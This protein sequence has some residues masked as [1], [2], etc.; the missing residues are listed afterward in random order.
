MRAEDKIKR[1]VLFKGCSIALS[2][3]LEEAK[4][5]KRS[6]SMES[7]ADELSVVSE[8]VTKLRNS[9]SLSFQ[10]GQSFS[11]YSSEQKKMDS[12]MK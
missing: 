9:V 12:V 1:R 10:E 3:G 8:Q 5:S 11:L 6:E 2:L 7:I 4:I